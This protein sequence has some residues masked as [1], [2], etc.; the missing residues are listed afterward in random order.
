MTSIEWT[1]ET[2]NPVTGC[3]RCSPGCDNCYALSLARR[4]KAMGQPHY[5]TDG[6]PRTSGPGF[7]LKC[8]SDALDIP[9]RWKRPRRVFVN[10]MSDLFHPAVPVDFIVR[11]FAVMARTPQHTYQVLT[12]RPQR[13]ELILNRP[14]F[15]EMVD[16]RVWEDWRVSVEWVTEE[17][18]EIGE[19]GWLPNVWLGTSIE[20]DRYT[21]RA[22]RLRTTPSAVRFVSAEPLLGP[23]PS[24]NLT[25]IDWLIVG[26]ESGPG[27]R[28]MHPDWVRELRDRCQ[29]PEL[30]EAWPGDRHTAF[31]FKQWGAWIPYELDPQPPFWDS[32]HLDMIDGHYLPADL[33]Q[34]DPV[35]GWWA[36]MGDPDEETAIYRRVGK[37]VAGRLLDGVTWDEYPRREA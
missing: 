31:F 27:A 23:L 19:A 22:D 30:N 4:L 37:K 33:S 8:H 34:G 14:E 21:F 6:D 17:Y 18:P 9:L 36:P 11:V 7:G 1:D 26:G 5:Q 32:Q 10:S 24:L 25:G 28:P 16:L 12:K 20:S 3:D 2:W 29:L 15:I 35:A 13:M